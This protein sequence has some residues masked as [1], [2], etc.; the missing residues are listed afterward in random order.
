MTVVGI[1][2]AGAERR[3]ELPADG[4]F[5][6]LRLLQIDG[7]VRAALGDEEAIALLLAGTFD[8]AAN[9]NHWGGRGARTTPFAGRPLALFLPPQASLAAAGRGEILL[10]GCRQTQAAVADAAATGRAALSQSPLLPLAGSGKAYDPAT[11]EWRMAETFPTS[12]EILP[13]RRIERTQLPGCV[14]ERVFPPAYKASTL[15]VDEVVLPAGASL[16]VAALPGR[17][18]ATELLVFVRSAGS[19]RLA[20]DGETIELRGDGAALHRHERGAPRLHVGAVDGDCYVV[21]AHAGK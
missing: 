18:P 6:S 19:A 10:L 8:L 15:S 16:D 11:G 12:P 13:P 4:R 14:V 3:G 1:A 9:G 20:V 17:P 7:D 2:P 5:T 21:L